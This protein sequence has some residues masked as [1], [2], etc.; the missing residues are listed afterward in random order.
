[1]E[2][3]SDFFSVALEVNPGV[4]VPMEE[5][6]SAA[7]PQT[8]IVNAP[9]LQIQNFQIP[10]PNFQTPNFPQTPNPQTPKISQPPNSQILEEHSGVPVRNNWSH[11]DGILALITEKKI[12][13]FFSCMLSSAIQRI[14]VWGCE[15]LLN[16]CF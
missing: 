8:P 15:I 11:V 1:L 6:N 9:S 16:L 2:T 12:L 14:K 7:V 5:E 13:D 10:S 4:A 3:I